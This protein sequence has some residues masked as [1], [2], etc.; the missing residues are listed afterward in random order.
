M[1]GLKLMGFS[2]F[3]GS[4]PVAQATIPTDI[5]SAA[6]TLEQSTPTFV[7]A[8][9]CIVFA[10][11]IVALF[12]Q[13]VKQGDRHHEEWAN[14]ETTLAAERELRHKQMLEM[15]E[16]MTSAMVGVR[17]VIERCDRIRAG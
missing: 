12:K 8:A 14:R 6:K 15:G 9:I 7:L 4:L 1:T 3:A 10:Y 11:T 2:L 13:F 16:K 17:T 5:T